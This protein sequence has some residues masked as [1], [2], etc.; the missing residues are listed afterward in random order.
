MAKHDPKWT[1]EADEGPATYPK[2][3]EE[4]VQQ[5]RARRQD[6]PA[7][8]P[9]ETDSETGTPAAV[10]LNARTEPIQSTVV[11]A[12]APDRNTDPD[13]VRAGPG[14]AGAA[15][16][17]DRAPVASPGRKDTWT[18]AFGILAV[19]LVVAVLIGLFA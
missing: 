10:P 17:P 3:R 4:L 8:A 12:G 16:R 6:E 5:N 1:P 13:D 19:V 18:R 11:E 7:A 15:D 9:Q 14:D 2:T